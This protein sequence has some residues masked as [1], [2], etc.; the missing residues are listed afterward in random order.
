MTK[1]HIT[2]L[3]EKLEKMYADFGRKILEYAYDEAI[4][5]NDLVD[6]IIKLKKERRKLIE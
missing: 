3:E 6:Q 4:E 1:D 2:E 5:I